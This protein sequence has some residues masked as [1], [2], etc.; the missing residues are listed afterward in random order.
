M[1]KDETLIEA[2]HLFISIYN[3]IKHVFDMYVK[4][5]KMP[6]SYRDCKFTMRY[7]KYMQWEI[8]YLTADIEVTCQYL[9]EFVKDCINYK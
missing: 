1:R 9:H 7:H 4:S 2:R 5:N 8:V 6:S 3:L